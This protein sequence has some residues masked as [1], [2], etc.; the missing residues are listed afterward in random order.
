[1]GRARLPPTGGAVSAWQSQRPV[2]TF[3]TTVSQMETHR[4]WLR[5]QQPGPT[6]WQGLLGG[7]AWREGRP[8]FCPLWTHSFRVSLFFF[9][10]NFFD[11][12]HLKNL[13]W[14]C[15]NIASVLYFGFG[16]TGHV[17]FSSRNRDRT[18]IPCIGRWSL[19]HWTTKKYLLPLFFHFKLFILYWSIA[20]WQCC[21]FQGNNEGTEPYIYTYP[22][23]PIQA[24]T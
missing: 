7:H 5:A 1:M 8:C 21:E 2:N 22:S 14:I 12:D 15:Y 6:L 24:A 4:R 17:G 9:F 10:T 23:P 11:V 16:A 13:S 19:N 3:L 20:S 18:C